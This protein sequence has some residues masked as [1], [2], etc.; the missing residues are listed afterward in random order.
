M[1]LE[2]SFEEKDGELKYKHTPKSKLEDMPKAPELKDFWAGLR[3]TVCNEVVGNQD[4]K[5][6]NPRLC[7][8]CPRPKKCTLIIKDKDGNIIE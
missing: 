7:Y 2:H 4:T 6:T 1:T 5:S 3:C 8:K